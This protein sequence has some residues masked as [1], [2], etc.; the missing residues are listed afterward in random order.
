[1]FLTR[2][3]RHGRANDDGLKARIV[4][5]DGI[6]ARLRLHVADATE[7]VVWMRVYAMCCVPG[8]HADPATRYLKSGM[9][10]VQKSQNSCSAVIDA[11]HQTCE[12]GKCVP[13]GL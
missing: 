1:M 5:I 7:E 3:L 8:I 9:G 13:V 10:D 11:G 2:Q 4:K 12:F 6:R